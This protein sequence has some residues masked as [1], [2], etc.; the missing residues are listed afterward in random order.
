MIMNI[1]Q[2]AFVKQAPAVLVEL[3]EK[4]IVA[5][6]E[7]QMSVLGNHCQQVPIMF[8]K[9]YINAAGRKAKLEVWEKVC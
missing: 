8:S 5:L 3:Q 4:D 2:A 7:G 9:E 6:L 1:I